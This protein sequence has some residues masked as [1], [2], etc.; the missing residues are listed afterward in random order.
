[1]DSGNPQLGTIRAKAKVKQKEKHTYCVKVEP[2]DRTKPGP[3][4][5]R[6]AKA[7]ERN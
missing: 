1:M 7:K 2:V 6:S 4:K 5:L 3:K